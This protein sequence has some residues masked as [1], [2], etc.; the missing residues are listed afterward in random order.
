MQTR[1]ELRGLREALEE[2][3][4]RD[5]LRAQHFELLS[6][7]LG[8]MERSVD[9]VVHR[10]DAKRRARQERDMFSSIFPAPRCEHPARRYLHSPERNA[11]SKTFQFPVPTPHVSLMWFWLVSE[12]PTIYLRC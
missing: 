8:S 12:K 9:V 10:E 6:S 5:P 11:L 2:L 4:H 3:Q 1:G 7:R